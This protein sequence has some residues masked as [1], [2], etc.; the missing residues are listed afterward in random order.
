M[1]KVTASMLQRM[2]RMQSSGASKTDIAK[3]LGVDRTTVRYWLC[4]EYREKHNRRS[5]EYWRQR[6]GVDP[7]F[8][9]HQQKRARKTMRRYRK[10]KDWEG[11]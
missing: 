2:E 4:R 1:A 5:R 9:E 6:Y 7:A 11:L 3:A 10:P 8:T